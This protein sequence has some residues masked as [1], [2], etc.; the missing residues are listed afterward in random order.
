MLQPKSDRCQSQQ[1]ALTGDLTCIRTIDLQYLKPLA[2]PVLLNLIGCQIGKLLGKVLP[3]FIIDPVTL[4]I[5][6]FI[7]L[8]K[9]GGIDDCGITFSYQVSSYGII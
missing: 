2:T 8:L 7:S 9:I 1:F 3:H 4:E 5:T 6:V